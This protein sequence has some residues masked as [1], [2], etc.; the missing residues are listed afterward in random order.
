MDAAPPPVHVAPAGS[1]YAVDPEEKYIEWMGFSFYLG[2]TRDIGLNLH[3]I[4]YEGERILYELS[5]QEALA[6]YAG[7]D[8]TQSGTAYLD[9][10][11]GFG[12]YA[13]ELVK[14]Y[15]CPAHAV[16]LNSSFYVSE[17]HRIHVDSICLFEFDADYVIQ[18]HSTREY[19]S[20]T[21]NT[22]FVVRYVATIGNYDYT[23][24]YSF[25]LDGSIAVEVRASGYIQSAYFAAN[26]D[27]GF[28]IHDTLSG[29]MH[30]HVINFKA[31][32]DILG[33]ENSVELMSMVPT[34]T[35]YP[36]SK[37]KV[38]NTMKLER[39]FIETEDDGQLDWHTPTQ[40]LVVNEQSPNQYGELRGYRVL[41]YTGASHLT[42]LN[43]SNLN[44][45]ARWAE[46]DIYVTKWKDTEPRSAHPYNTQDTFEPPVDFSKFF[47]G[48]SLRNEDLVLWLNLGMHH[49]PHTGDLPNTVMTTAHS[50]VQ[51]MPSNYFAGDE[52]RRTRNQVRVKFG[53]GDETEVETFGQFEAD[54]ATCKLDYTPVD[55]DLESY[56]G[57]IVVRKFPFDPNNPFPLGS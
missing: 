6:H 27:Y 36:W 40:V 23:F 41:P 18:R 5:M 31:D 42:V 21:K 43:S 7:N 20:I 15:D 10:Y 17:T 30:D 28:Q 45:A 26:K 1:R 2:F 12:P 52:S 47:D 32:F 35:T 14:G 9:S 51:F 4:R 48:E 39:S 56:V 34:T 55:A 50:G 3:D 49:V 53:G 22:Y 38:R 33:T 44:N 54:A 8:P 19:V 25:F 16:Y 46:H 24:S 13:F 37:G 11:Y 29:S 57:D